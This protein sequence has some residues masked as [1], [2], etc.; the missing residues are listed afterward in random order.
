MENAVK[1][2]TAR[3]FTAT[4]VAVVSPRSKDGLVATLSGLSRAGL[5]AVIISLGDDPEPARRDEDGAIV[6][7]GLL[8]KYLDNAVASLRLSS[9]PTLAWWR[10]D[11][12]EILTSLAALVD[13]VVLDVEDPSRFWP[14]VPEIASVAAVS[15]VRWAR[16]TRLRELFAQFFDI[17]EVRASASIFDAVRVAGSD[18][19]QARLAAGWLRS[20]L[21]AGK[22]LSVRFERGVSAPVES[23]QLSGENATLGVRLRPD[24]ACMET[25][26]QIGAAP[27]AVRVVAAGDPQP[28]SLIAEELRV[29]SRDLAFEDAVRA[30][31]EWSSAV[32]QS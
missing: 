6:I 31:A 1:D 5:R 11:D 25:S 7:D 9:L 19:F 32:E 28:Q 4:V 10:A 16:L 8:P 30:A 2:S 18:P 20:R 17:P 29:R 23:L 14:L 21:P 15:D 3:V 13:R 27:A 26:V 22:R 24:S 12:P